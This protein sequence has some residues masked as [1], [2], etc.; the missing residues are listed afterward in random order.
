MR[1]TDAP[2]S[3]GGQDFIGIVVPHDMALDRELWRWTPTDISLLFTRTPYTDLP[4]TLELAET[5][6]D[7]DAVARATTELRTVRP[8][9]YAYGCTSGSFVHG[10]EGEQ[11][12]RAA[13]SAAGE[14]HAVTTSGALLEALDQLGIA[15]VAVATPYNHSVTDRLGTF[16]AE[17]GVSVVGEAHLGLTSEI[18]KVPYQQ[19]VDLV[20]E[21]DSP[22]AQAIV[23]SCTNLPTYDVIAPLEAELGKPVITANQ[24]TMW[25]VLGRAGRGLLG[26]GQ[27]LAAA[28]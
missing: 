20:R 9:A 28:R 25:A 4:V 15:Q 7:I 5:V 1:T 18:W 3:P 13:M 6:G 11:Q 14:G 19:T 24:A 17:A 10:V 16:L 2:P 12:L 21:A 26:P 22:D 8:V 27:R 23:V